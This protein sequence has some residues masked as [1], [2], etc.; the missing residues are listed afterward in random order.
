[1]PD[2]SSTIREET[3][4]GTEITIGNELAGLTVSLSEFAF[5]VKSLVGEAKEEEV[6]AA[7]GG[8]I[9]EVRKSYDTAVEAF[10]PLY[11]LDTQRKFTNRFTK[12]RADFKRTYLKDIGKVRTHCD[13]VQ[14]RLE[15]LQRRKSWMRHLPIMRRAFKRLEE[16]S[17][18]WIANDR[19]LAMNMDILLR[20]LNDLMN[21]VARMSKK[22]RKEA[23]QYLTDALEMYEDLLLGVR[24]K[25]RVLEKLSQDLAPARGN[26]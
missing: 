13:I 17:D 7:L 26:A 12:I 20:S 8:M 15:E 5:A 1:M 23:Y 2:D 3:K 10:A 19:W 22:S 9:E 6:R 18:Y 16:L 11:E 24:K 25:L 14:S 21:K 4:M